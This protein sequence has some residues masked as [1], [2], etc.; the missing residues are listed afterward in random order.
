MQYLH[1]VGLLTIL[2]TLVGPVLIPPA[3]DAELATGRSLGLDLPD[4]AQLVW[5]TIRPLTRATPPRYPPAWM[6]VRPKCSRWPWNAPIPSSFSM[7]SSHAGPPNP[8]AFA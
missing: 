6:R 8:S 4:P 3:V 2:P 5:L 7:T 1:Q